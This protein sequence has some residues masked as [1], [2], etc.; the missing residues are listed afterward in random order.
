[1]W[2]GQGKRM[3]EGQRTLA[4][5]KREC[6]KSRARWRG[7]GDELETGVKVSLIRG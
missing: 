1:M 6:V 4:S 2:T 3:H 7:L 5:Y